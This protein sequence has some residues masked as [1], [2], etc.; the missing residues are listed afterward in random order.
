MSEVHY[1]F[2]DSI[3]FPEELRQLEVQELRAFCAEVREYLI[4]CVSKTGG[5]LGAGLGA[6]E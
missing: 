4:D 3:N 1:Q 6:V 2:L 5:H